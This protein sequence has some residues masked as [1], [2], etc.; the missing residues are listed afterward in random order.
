MLDKS[1][2]LFFF[3]QTIDQKK[4]R[5]RRRPTVRSDMRAIL[6]R[7]ELQKKFDNVKERVAAGQK[8]S[9]SSVVLAQ[10]P[11]NSRK[12][13]LTYLNNVPLVDSIIEKSERS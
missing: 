11:L 4:K 6:L 9:Q 7:R 2:D 3:L 8:R 5:A 12:E 13:K 1:V 10:F